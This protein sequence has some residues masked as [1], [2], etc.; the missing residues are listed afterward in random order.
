MVKKLSSLML[1]ILGA[2][3]ILVGCGD[4]YKKLKM[5]VSTSEIILYLH[6]STNEDPE[7][8]STV[9]DT[10]KYP[11]ETNFTVKMSGVKKGVSSE[12][13][14]TQYAHNAV[15][16][17]VTIEPEST[18]TTS[19]EGAKY[20]V[21]ALRPGNGVIIV[22][23]KEGN[24]RHEIKVSVL[25]PITGLEFKDSPIAVK[26]N[27]TLNLLNYIKPIP[28]YTDE[29]SV[30]FY[31][32]DTVGSNV[33]SDEVGIVET[34]Y[35][36][37]ENG[38]L[39]SKT[40]ANYP[41]DENGIDYVSVYAVSNA[42][43]NIKTEPIQIPVLDLVEESEISLI[44][45]NENANIK[46]T[47]N[48]NGYYEIVLGNNISDNPVIYSRD[49]VIKLS[50]D[51]LEDK[52]Y[53]ITTNYAGENKNSIF[54]LDEKVSETS[55][56]N[57]ASAVAAG[58][59]YKT[60]NFTQ[61]N[62]GSDELEIY[63]DRRGFEGLF[64]IT[65]KV[66]VTVKEF[67]T[68]ITALTEDNEDALVDG[69]TI[70]NAYGGN[71][72]GSGVLISVTPN[73]N[74]DAQVQLSFADVE[75]AKKVKMTL[76]DGTELKNGSM[77]DSGTMVYIR[78][79][80]EYEDIVN[81][82]NNGKIPTLTLY[83]SY[84]LA[85]D[86]VVDN[87]GSYNVVRDISLNVEAGVPDLRVPTG[88]NDLRINAVT[89]KAVNDVVTDDDGIV[90]VTIDNQ[91]ADLKSLIPEKNI[92]ILTVNGVNSDINPMDNKYFSISYIESD[93]AGMFNKIIIEPKLQPEQAIIEMQISTK[94]KITKNI[95]IEIF[96]PIV[97]S[98]G[99]DSELNVEIYNEREVSSNIYALNK[100][101]YDV[102][103][104]SD[105]SLTITDKAVAAIDE[106]GAAVTTVATMEYQSLN[107][108][109]VAVNSSIGLNVY[110]YIV[111]PDDF[112][113]SQITKVN[114][115]TNITISQN[116]TY[117]TIEYQNINGVNV[118]FIKVKTIKTDVGSPIDINIKVVGYDHNGNK[119]TLNKVLK[120]SIVE[121]ITN[122]TIS[123]LTHTLYTLNSVG[124]L[125]ANRS[126]VDLDVATLPANAGLNDPNVKLMFNFNND[127]VYR[128]NEK[129]VIKVE[130]IITLNPVTGVVT[131]TINEPVIKE[132]LNNYSA[133]TNIT[134]NYEQVIS[135]IFSKT[136]V[137]T[138]N[139]ILQQYEKPVVTTS[140]YISLVHAQQIENILPSV[141]KNGL[142]FDIRKVIANPNYSQSI[143][144][145]ILPFEAFNKTL[146]VEIG[147]ESVIQVSGVDDSGRLIGNTITVKTNLSAG[148]TYIR[149][150]AEDSY[151]YDTI[152]ES[153]KP[154]RY[155]DI[156]VRVADGSKQYPFEIANENEFKNIQNDF[157]TKDGVYTN[158]YYY[159]L[160]ESFSLT[161]NVFEPFTG[162]FN[163]GINGNFEYDIAGITYSQQN[164]IF[165]V[166]IQ[167]DIA[168]DDVT[169][170]YDYGIFKTI[171]EK[172]E[173]ENL[174]ISDAVINFNV[175][176]SAFAGE[177]NLGIIAGVNYGTIVNSHVEG[178][179]NVNSN[180]KN[181]NVGGLVG[182]NL[183]YVEIN[184]TGKSFANG[185]IT[186]KQLDAISFANETENVNVLINYVGSSAVT[187]ANV[188]LGGVTGSA[189][190]YAKHIIGGNTNYV[191][192]YFGSEALTMSKDVSIYQEYYTGGSISDVVVGAAIISV[193]E[194]GKPHKAN[195][196]GVAGYTNSTLISGVAVIPGLYGHSNVGGIVGYAE[197]SEIRDSIVEFANQGQ[198]GESTISMAAYTNIGGMVGYAKNVNVMYSYVRAYFNNKAI[199]NNTY[200]GNI[201]LLSDVAWLTDQNIGGLIGYVESDQMSNQLKNL[202]DGKALADVYAV[203]GG[204]YIAN[205]QTPNGIF[206]SY[207]NADI[208]TMMV[209]NANVGGLVGDVA[210][211]NNN[212]KISN[213][214]VYGNVKQ[215]ETEYSFKIVGEQ[216][217]ATKLDVGTI[218][219]YKKG[220]VTGTFAEVYVGQTVDEVINSNINSTANMVLQVVKTISNVSETENNDGTTT[221]TYDVE[222]TVKNHGVSGRFVGSTPISISYVTGR[223]I[224]EAGDLEEIQ[225]RTTT[226]KINAAAT[227][228]V[229]L[230]N[231][232]YA[233]NGFG[234]VATNGSYVAEQ[235]K[236]V[237]TVIVNKYSVVDGGGNVTGF[238]EYKTTST[239]SSIALAGSNITSIG[240]YGSFSIVEANIT[241]VGVYRNYAWVI[242]EELN[243]GYPLLF[244]LNHTRGEVLFKVLPTEI[245]IKTATIPADF[246]NTSF[247]TDDGKIIL[248]YNEPLSG[249]PNNE[250]NYYR[251]V[252]N[253]VG[254][255]DVRKINTAL[256]VDLDIADLERQYGIMAEYDKNMVV[257]SS[258]TNVITVEGSSFLK[259]NGVGRTVLTVS[260]RLDVSI[261]DTID[262]LVIRGV[263]DLNI[264]KAKNL[265]SNDNKL[266]TINPSQISQT[267]IVNSINQVIDQVSNY[268]VDFV[269][270]DV[271]LISYNGTY[272]KNSELGIKLD[273]SSVG[274][275]EATLNGETLQKGST[276]LFTSLT[277]FAFSGVKKG[278]LYVT[279]TPI[280]ITGQPDFGTTL[281][282]T[283]GSITELNNCVL[284][285]QL[286][287]IYK[288]NI[289]PQAESIALDKNA[290]NLDPVKTVDL[291]IST[292]TS[293]FVV[294]PDT[295]VTV[296]EQIFASIT[297]NITGS[298]VGVFNLADGDE[299]SNSSFINFEVLSTS[300]KEVGDPLKREFIYTI[301]LSFDKERYQN[302]SGGQTYN[303]NDMDYQIKFYP[304]SNLNL[305]AYFNIK[306]I[307]RVVTN[308]RS[309]YYP[310]S[311]MNN[312]GEYFPQENSSNY[313][314]PSQQGLLKLELFPDFNNAEY[315]EITVNNEM[316]NFVDF[317]QQ[318]AVMSGDQ[319]SYVTSY[320]SLATQTE[321]LPSFKGIRLK[322]QSMLINGS[323]IY[324][325]GKFF[326]N[327]VLSE[328]AP[329]NSNIEFTITAYKTV[330]GVAQEIISEKV[331]LEVQ[332]LPTVSLT[333]NGSNE[334]IIAKGTTAELVVTTTNFDGDIEFA[335][336]TISG[337]TSYVSY[338]YDLE[339]QKRYIEVYNTAIAGDTIIIS[340][341]VSR[342][343]NGILEQATATAKLHVVEYE[344]TGGYLLGASFFEGKYQFEMLNGTTN[345]LN[346]G[347]TANYNAENENV[348]IL[349]NYLSKQASGNILV[350]SE[351]IN[352]WWYKID[353][354][355]YQSLI[356]GNVYANGDFE[357]TEG[358]LSDL[359]RT[360][361]YAITSKL[362]SD[363]NV[364]KFMMKYYYNELG[365]P[366]LVTSLTSTSEKIY[367]LEF[368]VT[369]V[370]KDNSTYDHPNPISTVEEF[371]AL[372]GLYPDGTQ[373]AEGP[374]TSGHYILV[375][376][377]T[378]DNYFPFE[379]NF[380]SLDGNGHII[381]LNSINTEKY[382]SQNSGNIGL[383]ETVSDKTVLKN[384]TID[385]SN[386]L[387][388][389]SQANK[390]LA[391]EQQVFANIDL[392]HISSFTFG[393]VT[394]EN[395]GTI[396]N[397]KL[398]NTKETS[399]SNNTTKNVL[400]AST[401]GYIDGLL[402]QATIGGLV[403]INNGSIS[404]SYVGLNANNYEVNFEAGKT[405][406]SEHKG[407]VKQSAYSEILTYPFAI[408]G[409]KSIG[410]FVN[411][412]NGTITNSYALGVGV[413]NTTYI[414]EGAQTAGFVVD[415][416][417]N[418][419][420]F[421]CMVE[422]V[423]TSNY[424]ADKSVYLE[425]KGFIGGFVY[426]NKGK[427]TNAYSNIHITTNSG[428]SGGFVY[429]NQEKG[430]ITN[431]YSTSENAVNSLSHGQ[432][433][434]IDDK[435]NYN[436]L[437]IMK[438]CFYLTLEGE[439]P[440]VNEPATSIIGTKVTGGE[441]PAAREVQG[442]A[443]GDV[444]NP[445]RYTDSFNG[446]N[447]ALGNEK[448]NIWTLGANQNFGPRLISISNNST[449]SHRILDHT[450][451]DETTK[452]V[453]Y[454]YIYD[455]GCMYG[456]E[457]NPLLVNTAQEFATFIINNARTW[458]VG[459]TNYYIFG[460]VDA[461]SNA[462][463]YV[464]L[465]NDLDF[466]E[467]TLNNLIVDRKRISDITFAGT[468]DGNGMK[469]TGIRLVDQ[470][471]DA[472][473]ENFGLFSQIGLSDYQR[474]LIENTSHIE[475]DSISTAL[476]N[477][478]ITINGFDTTNAVKVG[479]LAGSIYNSALINI[480]L[481]GGEGVE[482]NGRNI[483][484]G[485]AGLILNNQQ[486]ITDIAINNI[487]VKASHSS[488]ARV[489]EITKVSSGGK[490]Y[491][492]TTLLSFKSYFDGKF[493]NGGNANTLNILRNYSYA[494]S[495]AGIIEAN[496][497]SIDDMGAK[498]AGA[499][500]GDAN[501]YYDAGE[502]KVVEPQ[503]AGYENIRMHRTDPKDNIIS[504]ITVQGGG[505]VAAEQAGGLF[506]YIGE[507]THIKNSKYLVGKSADSDVE[508]FV[509]QI[510][511]Y[512]YA[513]GIVAE[514]YGMIEQCYVEHIKEIQDAITEAYPT[515][516]VLE[517]EIVNLFGDETGIATPIAVG[518]IAGFSA[519]SII[520]DSYSLI[521]VVNPKAKIAGGLIGLVGGRNYFGHVFT[522]GD[523]YAKYVT[524]GLIGLHTNL[525]I[526]GTTAKGLVL[527]YAFAMNTWG[528]EAKQTLTEILYD[529]YYGSTENNKE[530]F[531]LR[532]PE[533]GNIKPTEANNDYVVD[534][535][536]SY[537]VSVTNR[538]NDNKYI[539]SL[540][541]STNNVTL[542]NHE[543]AWKNTFRPSRQTT[544]INNGKGANYLFSAVQSTTFA[545]A[546]ITDNNVYLGAEKVENDYYAQAYATD[547]TDDLVFT[548]KIGQQFSLSTIMGT[549]GLNAPMFTMFSWDSVTLKANDL[550]ESSSQ[551]WKVTNQTKFPEY[552]IGVYS[553]FNEIKD[554]GEFD[555]KIMDAIDTKNQFYMVTNSFKIDGGSGLDS[556]AVNLPFEGT[557]IGKQNAGQ[558]P[559][560]TLDVSNSA[561]N[562]RTIF[563]QLNSATISNVDFEII[564]NSD[565]EVDTSGQDND[566]FGFF[567]RYLTGSV[568]N[569]VNITIQFAADKN[570]T[571]SET[572]SAVGLA[573]GRVS[574][575]TL[576]N[577]NVAI[578]GDSYKIL[579]E[580]DKTIKNIGGAIGSATESNL[581]NVS[582]KTAGNEETGL[583]KLE[584][585][586]NVSANIGG[587][588]GEASSNTNLININADYLSNTDF[589]NTVFTIPTDSPSLNYGGVVGRQKSGLITDVNFKGSIKTDSCY[590]SGKNLQVGGIAGELNT[591]TLTHAR[592]N[593]NVQSNG[594]YSNIDGKSINIESSSKVSVGG[595]VGYAK[596]STIKGNLSI[597]KQANTSNATTI[598]VK[599]SGAV[600]TAENNVGGI[601]G[602]LQNSNINSVFNAGKVTVSG[603]ND[604][605]VGGIVG[606]VETPNNNTNTIYNLYNFA[607]VTTETSGN[608]S[609]GALFG[610]IMCYGKTEIKGF[611]NFA[612][613]IVN[614]LDGAQLPKAY[615]YTVGGVAGHVIGGVQ[616]KNGYTL[617]RLY[618]LT[619]DDNICQFN[620]DP[621]NNGGANGIAYFG[622]GVDS[623]TLH[624]VFYVYE[625]APYSSYNHLNVA[626][627]S[628]NKTKLY[629][630]ESDSENWGAIQ[631]TQISN[632]L[633]KK[634]TRSEGFSGK[635]TNSNGFSLRVLDNMIDI[636]NVMG[637]GD[638]I[639]YF[640][641]GNKLYPERINGDAVISGAKDKYYVI[642]ST[643]NE[644]QLTFDATTKMFQ[645]VLI[646]EMPTAAAKI[647]CVHLEDNRGIMANFVK[648][649]NSASDY[650]INKNSGTIINV[651]TYG[652]IYSDTE[653][654]NCTAVNPFAV[655]NQG[656]IIQCGSNLVINTPSLIKSRT[657]KQG[658]D[659][660]LP[661]DW[662]SGF[663]KE[664]SGY[665]KDCFSTTSLITSNPEQD[666]LNYSIT[667]TSNIAGF[668]LIN[669]GVIET[670]YYAGSLFHTDIAS[671]NAIVKE[672]K[673]GGKI[674]NC[675]Y[676][677]EATPINASAGKGEAKLTEELMVG[678][679]AQSLKTNMIPSNWASNINAHV[680]FGNPQLTNGYK[681]TMLFNFGVGSTM[682]ASFNNN[683]GT[684]YPLFHIGQLNAMD[685][686]IAN[687]LSK[688]FALLTNL[689]A[690][691]INFIK[692]GSKGVWLD[693]IDLTN[694]SL[695][696]YGRKIYNLKFATKFDNAAALFSKLGVN[697]LVNDMF[698]ENPQIIN[699]ENTNGVALL[700]KVNNGL[701]RGIEV[702]NLT[703]DNNSGSFG[704][705]ANENTKNGTIDR[706]T[707]NEMRVN[708]NRAIEIGGI[709][710][711]NRGKISNATILNSEL[712]ATLR[713]G[714]ITGML[715][716]S[717]EVLNSYVDYLKIVTTRTD[718]DTSRN[719]CLGGIV[720][721]SNSA[722]AIISS[723]TVQNITIHGK[724]DYN[725]FE[726]DL[727]NAS[728]YNNQTVAGKNVSADR[729][730]EYVCNPN[731][732]EIGKALWDSQ[733]SSVGGIVGSLQAGTVIASQL[734]GTV[735]IKGYSG[736]GGVAGTIG[737]H[738]NIKQG[739][740][741]QDSD[742]SNNNASVPDFTDGADG[743]TIIA[744]FNVGGIAGV[745][746]GTADK[747]IDG[748]AK[749]VAFNTIGTSAT[750]SI[751]LG[752]G[753]IVG[754]QIS[755]HIFNFSVSTNNL[756]GGRLV[757]GA[758]GFSTGKVEAVNVN[759][760]HIPFQS[761]WDLDY[762]DGT[763]IANSLYMGLSSQNA[764]EAL[765]DFD[766]QFGMWCDDDEWFYDGSHSDFNIIL[767][768]MLANEYGG[769]DP[770]A[771]SHVQS[772][773][774][775]TDNISGNRA[776]MLL[777]GFGTGYSNNGS[778]SIT[779]NTSGNNVQITGII[780]KARRYYVFA[781]DSSYSYC[782]IEKF[783][784]D[785][786][787]TFNIN[788]SFVGWSGCL[789]GTNTLDDSDYFEIP[790]TTERYTNGGLL[791]TKYDPQQLYDLAVG[792]NREYYSDP[793]LYLA[794]GDLSDA[795][796]MDP[797][798]FSYA[799][800]YYDD[801]N[802]WWWAFVSSPEFSNLYNLDIADMNLVEYDP[803]HPYLINTSLSIKYGT[804]MYMGME[805]QNS[806][807][808]TGITDLNPSH[809]YI[810]W[811]QAED[812]WNYYSD[813]KFHQADPVTDDY[814]VD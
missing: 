755:G 162:V 550:L 488:E 336:S 531:V 582:V 89:G 749:N 490:P 465:V 42:N 379:A 644:L 423:N 522:I 433:T 483:V 721:W 762:N 570:I 537:Y 453:R 55:R 761:K 166:T 11:S 504:K 634:L 223:V 386:M 238:V 353:D 610:K 115:N 155:L 207:F 273:V 175:T 298:V 254:E 406:S 278:L 731:T 595:V 647:T 593:T 347:L 494:G 479:A 706:I 424:R 396:T 363:D 229:V 219:E 15:R 221:Y 255:I 67:G 759:K 63:I 282:S 210:S 746:K 283:A 54:A 695:H 266:K 265:T 596:S 309:A 382:K 138:V 169:A 507:T 681:M 803:S 605:R 421:N 232:Y 325:N 447:F 47:K 778:D 506:G 804:F 92:K 29:T 88:Y 590:N 438:S 393:F 19:K 17:I 2:M 544:I 224:T 571:F 150:A 791:Q 385:I 557:I 530:N 798:R 534:E 568:L 459:G 180:I 251:I 792:Y 378:L 549:N 478:D 787:R 239:L 752:V 313:I 33:V 56:Y 418:G 689:F 195:I 72:A 28:E 375:N 426:E 567:A 308:V 711:Y 545:T 515:D 669:S 608:Y 503:K 725:H 611:I 455:V 234:D 772:G 332:P 509:Q 667:N 738:G 648:Q 807:I 174:K 182:K 676:D 102:V 642:A 463:S 149:V 342:Y 601:V 656:N 373:N 104:K 631:Y 475:T 358:Y 442:D 444:N 630:T 262:V 314:V 225:E 351:Y 103:L 32:D 793:D 122:I 687:G 184:P 729:I 579:L 646:G 575:S 352:N 84:T 400:I 589:T 732:N 467:I 498:I 497:R 356:R 473:H 677:A 694:H 350:N 146:I 137:V 810:C 279:I 144:F 574:A 242:C 429:I 244:K 171:G 773:G 101:L 720:G 797:L 208:N 627:L 705:I 734:K 756:Y 603:S 594:T 112:G 441:N 53:A 327:V 783:Y 203:E 10:E 777:L 27:S 493:E 177:V 555:T 638:A 588:V 75:V 395:N 52:Q 161:T 805:L 337:D 410:G 248:F 132:I 311:E 99:G 110:N 622:S 106:P 125:N 486:T 751:Y 323:Q 472:V 243:S 484:G 301:R 527:D 628:T 508:Q 533:V 384:I 779:I 198:I 366:E 34:S 45:I 794:F 639:N 439:T 341:T 540:I 371:M 666:T 733:Q 539:G 305:S 359:E 670:S 293:D 692:G 154:L 355:Q 743:K 727:L 663:V 632:V 216:K 329:V 408:V 715:Y 474:E 289:V 401:T 609:A 501:V 492:G 719:D 37:I 83:Y 520:L 330:N 394:A 318:L 456:T 546:K 513:G 269:N 688:D 576:Q 291:V 430:V 538:G 572:H 387:V 368:E 159:V 82:R 776:F 619:T 124:S 712:L 811:H 383:F 9:I 505:F 134:V 678:S 563:K 215:P 141:S 70:Y 165:G 259:V 214:Y 420:I 81:I 559:K 566:Y 50:D 168:P 397:A 587:V 181:L 8:E 285:E 202:S 560:I 558:N 199:D 295:S 445:F 226:F 661:I 331:I 635:S 271:G 612:D 127:I 79:S 153:H 49:L 730:L 640:S 326:V 209:V 41:T 117:Y 324:Y 284:I 760:A 16:D 61:L 392:K 620:A 118:P 391:D 775:I 597:G 245:K 709:T 95:V 674:V 616:L 201:A 14:L 399:M 296:N 480:T 312:L 618:N 502:T 713:I 481:N 431:A 529:V 257:S 43:P 599:V 286:T 680:N 345:S 813:K 457:G 521:D 748:W 476:I 745:N 763:H 808:T 196:G 139:A 38:V 68:E 299:G 477:I 547:G 247:V 97:Y 701:I 1:V 781:A 93:I 765:N 802:W 468:L 111:L 552:I 626:N 98:V 788:A 349:L 683:T 297:D 436:N 272:V 403:G 652:Y 4:P 621:Q 569:N 367:E 703:V 586:G 364:I 333:I 464:R 281:N 812:D 398:I 230:N 237:S 51:H 94:N 163:G 500:Y 487:T 795:E 105:D 300:V 690:D 152:S 228:N 785:L 21:T 440:N 211:V 36:K 606:Y 623:G 126:T 156:S 277:D 728:Y 388:T 135:S 44:T 194:N 458:T 35:A 417:I 360:H 18:D 64:T 585:V 766:T 470:Q 657:A 200:Y 13:N 80:F 31:I 561:S 649:L 471:K 148:R 231:C 796:N 686:L 280:I 452:E 167:K 489:S 307:P 511:G 662:F 449:F 800:D 718:S 665:I 143:S 542:I 145:E 437:G 186:T 735:D 22:N 698:I 192:A 20:K 577:V 191:G 754:S 74:K 809:D 664:N 525:P 59:P 119:I 362:V 129:Y 710:A 584:K 744:K 469:M 416:A 496:N 789:L 133:E 696:G 607:D 770:G 23:S 536:E 526:A 434:G 562:A 334:G 108:F 218:V 188:N 592:V 57:Y 684:V 425:A 767:K 446:F 717:G 668:A 170:N 77:I 173:I 613:A 491:N 724:T 91:A 651:T 675:Y 236:A 62:V 659:E 604:F 629:I 625:F 679:F 413:T 782:R 389:T 361:Y 415:N 344:L 428:G 482:I 581:T 46:L 204:N 700:V 411:T 315:V 427:I 390:I 443:K 517:S 740:Y 551:I 158:E 742:D 708:T 365:V 213:S 682:G 142:Y 340:A 685:K 454:D 190:T 212:L 123:P 227:S 25:V 633:N 655:I 757:G 697:R 338:N 187:D 96:V 591:V 514:N 151:Y 564:V 183:T 252:N 786:Q 220:L 806:T 107:E 160:S 114:Y 377:L 26:Y 348:E 346:V 69:L 197:H 435:N 615:N 650:L 412:N 753:G 263:S 432:F 641:S 222:V 253:E 304:Q 205:N 402:V 565:L 461:S 741:V 317:K 376:D 554:A 65:L 193:D 671:G 294:N 693:S 660:V 185:K 250:I 303:L 774:K 5:S 6:E 172:A 267:D 100:S 87:Y 140:S 335:I 405:F 528:S 541:G 654:T 339:T 583:I 535:K 673:N 258:N 617:A 316:K 512:N 485:L 274:E 66:K 370:I 450:T 60:F 769:V 116:R 722:N 240:S 790:A 739:D 372:G 71:V 598:N 381:T 637:E 409:G 747:N 419:N 448:N 206:N 532:M 578:S 246:T 109:T 357:F 292:I 643:V 723:S 523:V 131:S 86:G 573:I 404:N 73:T 24:K 264:Y 548:N 374:I 702:N 157:A 726:N 369:L 176:N 699:N 310:N 189:L 460:S 276:Y 736:V 40:D 518:G 130:H 624:K 495:V 462:V 270:E 524:G 466:S 90:L 704:T 58:Y 287:K 600:N 302:R 249:R 76:L 39:I 407:M 771:H 714:G 758:V 322:N 553:N 320:Q 780:E 85:P 672:N 288:F 799:F 235:Y 653:I 707:I 328:R 319:N 275:G 321:Y 691:N 519:N 764:N 256:N 750:D 716:D 113:T 636:T 658:G 784:Q 121:P 380:N 354:T 801:Y 510:M 737:E 556:N 78:H 241:N 128:L 268:Y 178:T 260:S 12:V 147:D 7:G 217:I 290:V 614:S 814:H 261:Y 164:E 233:V 3:L 543:S 422:G 414:F 179:I 768:G 120:L 30:S 580:T 48:V 645:G 516:V 306:I 499:Q 136:V 451:V 602:F 343:L